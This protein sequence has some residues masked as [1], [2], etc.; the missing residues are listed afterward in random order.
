MLWE[1]LVSGWEKMFE[2]VYT[3]HFDAAAA[4]VALAAGVT[5]EACLDGLGPID[6]L[7]WKSGTPHQDPSTAPDGMD[8]MS[9]KGSISKRGHQGAGKRGNPTD[10]VFEQRHQGAGKRGN[11]TDVTSEQRRRDTAQRGG[12]TDVELK[13]GHQGAGKRGNPTD[14]NSEQRRQPG[15]GPTRRPD[16]C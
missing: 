4:E 1:R 6:P 11:P 16:R 9:S 13:Q 15:H 14:V 10:V 5:T 2:D 7:G 12:P 8:Q 3:L